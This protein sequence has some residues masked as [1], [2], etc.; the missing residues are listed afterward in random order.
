M[1]PLTDS[2]ML[3]W[4]QGLHNPA[5]GSP[6]VLANIAESWASL[7]RTKEK[8]RKSKQRIWNGLSQDTS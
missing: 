4:R 8:S 2:R 1:D 5:S 7:Q 6:G 3:F